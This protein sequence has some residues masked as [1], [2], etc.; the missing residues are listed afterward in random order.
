MVFKKICLHFVHC[1]YRLRVIVNGA[2]CCRTC[3]AAH[4]GMAVLTRTIAVKYQASGIRRQQIHCDSHVRC[5]KAPRAGSPCEVSDH[6]CSQRRPQDKVISTFYR[7]GKSYLQSDLFPITT[8][9]SSLRHKI[10]SCHALSE[11]QSRVCGTTRFESIC[12]RAQ[13][14]RIYTG[15]NASLNLC[16]V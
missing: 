4:P 5:V 6:R 13:Q 3:T 12:R 15:K 7:R 2:V 9:A 11:L 1:L 8:L 14:M 10:P 16:R